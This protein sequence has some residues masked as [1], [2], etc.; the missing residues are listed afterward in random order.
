MPTTTVV[1]TVRV[2]RKQLLAALARINGVIPKRSMKPILEGVRLKAE[3]GDL[4]L[5][6]TDQ[7]ISL[8]TRLLVDGDLSACVVHAGELTR[9]LKTGKADTCEIQL[10][11]KD[12][13][14][15]LNGGRVEHRI[16]TMDLAE[17]PPMTASPRG[18]TW[19][20]AGEEFR[21]ALAITLRAA[22]TET[23]RYAING[24]LLECGKET[25]RL[26]A[27]DGRR[28]VVA[29]LDQQ[30]GKFHGQVLLPGAAATLVGKLIGKSNGKKEVEAVTVSIDLQVNGDGEKA[31][32]AIHVAGPD[33][34]VSF[35]EIEGCF[36]NYRDVLP[37]SHSK[38]V[39]D[40]RAFVETLGEVA[41]ATS[42]EAKGVRLDLSAESVRISTNSI[43]N[44]E[45]SGTVGVEFIGGGDDHII[46]G[47][48]PS[49][50]LDAFES[51]PDDRVVI[52]VA[53]NRL[54]KH[55]GKVT[56]SPALIHGHNSGTTRW[57][58]MSLNLD[59]EPSRET[60]GSNYESKDGGDST[61]TASSEVQAAVKREQPV[62]PASEPT[63]AS[64]ESPRRR[65][66][67]VEH[68]W[69]EIGTR[70]DG[71][72]MGERYAVLVI[73]APKLKAGCALQIINGPAFGRTFNSMS[74][75]MLAATAKQRRRLGQRTS[76]KG[77]AKSGW[78]FWRPVEAKRM[79]A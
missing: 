75:A 67:R 25:A 6:A 62:T 54:T 21:D 10:D 16:S 26:V 27:T 57:V 76:T 30:E 55:D 53:Q 5:T 63:S 77:L 39:V 69:P 18:A 22:A 58:V 79:S 78:D 51:L 49:F 60:L 33:W 23:T 45:A 24:V 71:E 28:M 17:F 64:T 73:A 1:P 32:A 9:R 4:D 52:D 65:R 13:A 20:A 47:F 74:A 38:F 46:A 12:G 7:N 59:L 56:G 48:N 72:F 37:K 29:D 42:L 44:G 15:V 43:T 41:V 31:P 2:D 36:P 14:L 61:A 50:L 8:V 19:H 35:A 40:R 66:R 70:L 3:R 34:S 68:T 11:E